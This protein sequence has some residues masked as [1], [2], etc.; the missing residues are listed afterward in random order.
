MENVI[1]IAVVLII[2]GLAGFYVYRA[3]KSADGN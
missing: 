3:K 1:V 2:L